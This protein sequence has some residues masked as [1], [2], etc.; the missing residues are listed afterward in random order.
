M[1]KNL[2]KSLVAISCL[3]FLAGCATIVRGSSQTIA[4]N[5]NVSGATIQLDGLPIG[6]TPFTGTIKKS[7]GKILTISKNGYIT[8][9]IHLEGGIDWIASGLGNFFLLNIFGTTTD[10]VSGSI[11]LYD[12]STYFI[13]LQK[14]GQSSLDFSKELAIRKFSMVN[15][16]QIAIDAGENSGEYVNALAELME[17]KMDKDTAVQNIK[18]ALEKSKGNQVAFGDALIESF[19]N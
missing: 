19:R 4:I 8:Q 10:Y 14:E 17:S 9:N 18:A 5:S 7:K 15:H 2:V 1:R 16:S 3:A 6:T 13:Q 12:P 11:W